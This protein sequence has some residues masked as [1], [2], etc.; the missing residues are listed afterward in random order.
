M[1]PVSSN[2]VLF[3]TLF[4]C[5]YGWEYVSDT[6]VS[7][8]MVSNKKLLL[9]ADTALGLVGLDEQNGQV[10]W[11]LKGDVHTCGNMALLD[12]DTLVVTC[13]TRRVPVVLFVN[14]EFGVYTFYWGLGRFFHPLYAA[15]PLK[16]N[17][18]DAALVVNADSVELVNGSMMPPSLHWTN[19]TGCNRGSPL[20]LTVNLVL[21]RCANN[22]L[23][24][25]RTSDNATVW[26]ERGRLPVVVHVHDLVV[27]QTSNSAWI[28]LQSTTGSV[29]SGTRLGVRAV[30]SESL[31]CGGHVC[32][33]VSNDSQ[34]VELT[35]FPSLHLTMKRAIGFT[36]RLQPVVATAGTI[37]LATDNSSSSSSSS[38]VVIKVDKDDIIRRF[39]V[40]LSTACATGPIL[41]GPDTFVIVLQDGR[42][43]RISTQSDV[44]EWIGILILVVGFLVAV[45]FS[46][47]H[48]CPKQMNLWCQKMNGRPEQQEETV[49]LLELESINRQTT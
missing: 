15:L 41:T 21:L 12:A 42:V 14:T 5:A 9:V 29:V 25:V 16:T 47:H 48:C 30:S 6:N 38:C 39:T 2:V 35:V 17:D 46:F 45:M 28:A 8:V 31:G 26:R 22:E 18:N 7:P 43:V 27:I 11:Q 24:A 3:L 49:P 20:A 36:T 32:Y 37:F 19:Y 4:G 33:F 23:V 34:L 40:S 13:L 10:V 1:G 44:L